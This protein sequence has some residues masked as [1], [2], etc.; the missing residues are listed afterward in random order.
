M[1]TAI[2][3]GATKGLGRS[4]CKQLGLKGYRV[5]LAARDLPRAKE[6][7]SQLQNDVPGG[8]FEVI[9]TPLDL[10]RAE[11][12]RE[13]ASA[14]LEKEKR[15]DVLLNNAGYFG[16]PN[17][18]AYV[19]YPGFG[20]VGMLAQTNFLGPYHLTRLLETRLIES[21]ARLVNMSSVAHRIANPTPFR[22][23]DASEFLR[24]FKSG[25]YPATKLAN[26]Y[27]SFECQ[28]LLGPL[29]VE[30]VAVDPGAVDTVSVTVVVLQCSKAL[31]AVTALQFHST[32]LQFASVNTP[33]P[34]PI[35]HLTAGHLGHEPHFGGTWTPVHP[36]H[37]L[38]SR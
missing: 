22:R 10:S 31:A 2:V 21:K 13:F 33:D 37:G 30:C 19:S 32:V 14:V 27:F 6:T 28:R 25:Y 34:P 15:I 35:M 20:R 16:R 7:L 26:V 17:E 23:G 8:R 1:K 11:S 9:D 4:C 12:V 36:P 5:L 29:G 3:T 18:E 24:N 38:L